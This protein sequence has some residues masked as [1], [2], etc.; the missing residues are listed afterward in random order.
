[1]IVVIVAV[2]L[3]CRSEPAAVHYF[4]GRSAVVRDCSSRGLTSIAWSRRP[5]RAPEVRKMLDYGVATQYSPA[6]FVKDDLRRQHYSATQA[7]KLMEQFA[8]ET[9]AHHPWTFAIIR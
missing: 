3:P 1:M 8:L 4:G 2:T 9:A 7:D 5:T 6:T